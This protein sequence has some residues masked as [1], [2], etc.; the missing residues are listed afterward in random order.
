MQAFAL[1]SMAKR[2]TASSSSSRLTACAIALASVRREPSAAPFFLDGTRRRG[3]Y[4][5]DWNRTADDSK[6]EGVNL[7]WRHRTER[8]QHQNPMWLH[9]DFQIIQHAI[10]LRQ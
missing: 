2:P 10:G 9:Q 6:P 4:A 1:T 8:R 3:D 7:L 5:G